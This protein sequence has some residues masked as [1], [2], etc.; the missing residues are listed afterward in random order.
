MG[1]TD[2]YKQVIRTTINSGVI[3]VEFANGDKIELSLSGI[4]ESPG[5]VD[6]ISE[7][8]VSL[9]DN[10]V[11]IDIPS[12]FI[13]AEGIRLMSDKDGYTKRRINQ[14]EEESRSIGKK[15]KY[16]RD[17]QGLSGTKLGNLIGRSNQ[18]VSRIE[19]GQ[20]S[21]FF[22][23]VIKIIAALGYTFQEFMNLDLPPEAEKTE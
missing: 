19:K 10:G 23:D 13:P 17:Q 3:E 14:A 5:S 21:I 1:N 22:P 8:V 15:V 20:G 2:D 11:S 18:V 6:I 4:I 7:T 16:I 9:I 12:I